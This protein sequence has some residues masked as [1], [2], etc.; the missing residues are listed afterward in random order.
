MS[1]KLSAGLPFI[2]LP[3]AVSPLLVNNLIG[4]DWFRL[5]TLLAGAS[6]LPRLSFIRQVPLT[7]FALTID[8]VISTL[9]LDPAG[10]LASGTITMPVNPSDGQIVRV[11]S[12]KAITSI[13]FSP[14]T[15]QAIANAPTS[16]N[17]G[18]G[19]EFVYAAA[20]T[21]WYELAAASTGA[22]GPVGPTG[23]TGPAGSPF[24]SPAG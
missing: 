15:G 24:L 22:T 3:L 12:S 4:K 1:G 11:A 10:T 21:T 18:D 16:F 6:N 19:Y 14:N 23:P 7:G 8:A 20:Q 17:A 5:L 2:K 13:T 9:I